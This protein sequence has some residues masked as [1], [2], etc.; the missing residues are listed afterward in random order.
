MCVCVCVCVCVCMYVCMTVCAYVCRY[1]NIY[2]KFRAGNL[3]H[4]CI[5]CQLR[6]QQM[7]SQLPANFNSENHIKHFYSAFYY[8]LKC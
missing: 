4:I 8:D 7:Y 1:V 2:E 5:K 3:A 6:N